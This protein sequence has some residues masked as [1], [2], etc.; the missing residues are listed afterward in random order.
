VTDD[1]ILIL[2]QD[3]NNAFMRRGADRDT[4]VIVQFARALLS[5]SIADTAGALSAEQ[6]REQFEADYATVWNAALKNNGWNGDHVAGDVKDLREGDT[7][8]EGRDYLNAR[9][10]GWQARAALNAPASQE[11][12]D[13]DTAWQVTIDSRDLFD[14]LRACWRDGQS[15][16]ASSEQASWSMATDYAVKA[17]E[18]LK[19]ATP[20]SSVADGGK[21][22]AALKLEGELAVAMSII[23]AMRSELNAPQAECA[24][25]QTDAEAL[26]EAWQNTLKHV[27]TQPGSPNFDGAEAYEAHLNAECAPR[28]AQPVACPHCWEVDC[29]T[30][31]TDAAPTPERADAAPLAQSAEQDRIDAERYR[32][33]RDK[34]R[35]SSP[36]GDIPTMTLSAPLEAPTHDTHK[37][38]ISDRF[39]ASVDRTID[40]AIASQSK[41][42]RS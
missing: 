40:A 28:E 17:I 39:D 33:L 35:F 20:A 14:K 13:A 22:E 4:P 5:A 36:P 29:L 31:G 7:Y 3:L 16:G 11:R 34:M 8:G 30:C 32:F 41:E 19:I 26:Y 24:P 18:F 15:Y 27:E 1:E 25:Q 21:G 2:W 10:E 23:E 42:P 6:E 9:W 37:D 38:W 12:A